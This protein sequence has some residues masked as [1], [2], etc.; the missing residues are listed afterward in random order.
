MKCKD[1]MSEQHRKKSRSTGKLIHNNGLQ[2]RC[3][4]HA[5]LG[6]QKN[7]LADKNLSKGKNNFC[8]TK[9]PQMRCIPHGR[10]GPGQCKSSW[11]GHAGS[12]ILLRNGPDK[13]DSN[14][15]NEHVGM[16]NMC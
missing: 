14:N 1:L 9:G 16:R 13:N 12:N 3:I 11:E 10:R 8:K 4:P 5:S 15:G 7:T 2:I 6:L